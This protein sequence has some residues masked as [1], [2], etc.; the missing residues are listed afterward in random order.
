MSPSW[1]RLLAAP[2][3]LSSVIALD[4]PAYP[5]L[6]IDQSRPGVLGIA[7]NSTN[8][9][10][11]IWGEETVS[12]LTDII[13][14]LQNDNETKVVLFTSDVPKYFI[15]HLDLLISPFGMSCSL[16]LFHTRNLTI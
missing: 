6:R 16:E 1:L 7:F 8:S 9:D 14:R 10:I 11:N 5:G 15:A 3:L 12:G 4:L 2:L 13:Q